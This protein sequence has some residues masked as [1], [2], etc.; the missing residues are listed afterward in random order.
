ML[1]AG[2]PQRPNPSRPTDK[3]C[4]NTDCT[5]AKSSYSLPILIVDHYVCRIK[6]AP[7]TPSS[8]PFMGGNVRHSHQWQ[9]S[10]NA[11]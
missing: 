10:S 9:N 6:G 1:D 5:V 11:A 7:R 2:C 8:K 3:R 4:R